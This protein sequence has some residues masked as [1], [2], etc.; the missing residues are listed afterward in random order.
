MSLVVGDQDDQR[1]E[2]KKE[3]LYE[4]AQASGI[5]YGALAQL[6]VPSTDTLTP[7]AGRRSPVTTRWNHELFRTSNILSLPTHAN[8]LISDKSVPVTALGNQVAVQEICGCC[9]HSCLNNQPLRISTWRSDTPLQMAQLRSWVQTPAAHWSRQIPTAPQNPI[10][11]VRTPVQHMTY[12]SYGA[13]GSAIGGSASGC[14]ASGCAAHA[15]SSATLDL[16]R[17]VEA[18]VCSEHSGCQ[19]SAQGSGGERWSPTGEKRQPLIEGRA[20]TENGVETMKPSDFKSMWDWNLFELFDRFNFFPVPFSLY[21]GVLVACFWSGPGIFICI[22]RHQQSIVVIDLR[23]EDRAA[24]TI[25]GALPI[26]ALEFL[27][28]LQQWC[29]EF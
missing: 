8:P 9:S 20:P 26:P 24:G 15:P 3:K 2:S 29:A 10:M 4:F 7:V 17:W 27:K 5:L 23:G 6:E 12:S 11:Y 14:S 19:C 13:D 22:A 21:L 16:C 25:A 28:D 1:R 18:K